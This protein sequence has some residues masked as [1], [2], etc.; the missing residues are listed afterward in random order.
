MTADVAEVRDGCSRGGLVPCRV[1][2]STRSNNGGACIEVA[3][4]MSEVVAVRDSKHRDGP[5]LIF[6]LH[7]WQSFISEVKARGITT[8]SRPSASLSEDQPGDIVG[9]QRWTRR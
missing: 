7:E 9:A 2:K 1:A 6:A 4:N 5:V 3:S 8:V